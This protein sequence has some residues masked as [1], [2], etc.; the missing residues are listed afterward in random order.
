MSPAANL[1]AAVTGGGAGIGE[2]ICRRLADDG[3]TVAVLDISGSGAQRTVD[4]L[5]GTGLALEVDV[6]D[7]AQVD[8]A[9]EQNRAGTRTARRVRQQCRRGGTRARQAHRAAPRATAA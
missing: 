6:S 9:V 3:A 8:A 1:I 2:A 7:S 4:R 5:A